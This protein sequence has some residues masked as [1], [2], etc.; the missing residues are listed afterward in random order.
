MP[1]LMLD[2]AVGL[3]PPR[4]NKVTL[5][6]P[7]AVDE[8]FKPLVHKMPAPSKFRPRSRSASSSKLPAVVVRLALSDIVGFA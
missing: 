7:A 1:S 6:L 3:E 5:P 8:A 4:A 2:P